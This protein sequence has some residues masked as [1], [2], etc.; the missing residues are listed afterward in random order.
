MNSRPLFRILAR[1]R[2]PFLVVLL[3]LSIF[4]V[5]HVRWN[6]HKPY[7]STT[8]DDGLRNAS[9]FVASTHWNNEHILRSHWNAAILSLAEHLGSE[10]VFV[11]IVES[12]SW[13]N[14]KGA[15]RDLDANLGKIGVRR[16][17]V[18]D[19]IT[20]ADEIA[21]QPTSEGWIMTPRGQMEPRRIPYLSR[22]RNT[23]IQPLQDIFLHH[24]RAQI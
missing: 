10:R 14:S 18:L 12:G 11:S 5:L 16:K 23:A 8:I 9:I 22:L 17:I 21:K 2:R 15:L 24:R 4:D 13:D 7:T 19:E 6:F 20:H 1:I 3:L